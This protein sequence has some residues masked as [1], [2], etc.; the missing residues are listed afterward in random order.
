MTTFYVGKR[1]IL[2]GRS[3]TPN[4]Y[5]G[6]LGR[7]S[8]WELMY[9]DH[10]LDGAPDFNHVP[11]IK[12]T[13]GGGEG[14]IQLSGM[15]MGRLNFVYPLAG[16]T[17]KIP[18]AS[19]NYYYGNWPLYQYHGVVSGYSGENA[20]SGGQRPIDLRVTF[21][22]LGY[23]PI[24]PLDANG[25]PVGMGRSAPYRVWDY[26]YHGIPN[27][28]V[29]RTATV[30]H[31]AHFTADEKTLSQGIADL[32][33]PWDVYQSAASFGHFAPYIYKGVATAFGPIGGG[34]AQ[35]V[36]RDFGHEVYAAGSVG[37]AN[38]HYGFEHVREW[39]GVPA[40]MALNGGIPANGANTYPTIA[41]KL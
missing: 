19:V 3:D 7:Y 23:S 24:L 11:G 30:G 6:L 15:F 41:P 27:T 17:N 2:K 33:Y 26:Y 16:A 9:R 25:N 14:D 39:F 20:A 34:T 38:D 13:S 32:G 29:F 40:T 36:F 35:E 5:T 21:G 10:V 1:P 12:Q 18:P 31:V 8:N 22:H 4:T 28:Q 37:T